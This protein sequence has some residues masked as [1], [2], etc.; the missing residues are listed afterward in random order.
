MAHW[1]AARKNRSKSA[2]R[3]AL[4]VSL[5]ALTVSPALA[6]RVN[7]APVLGGTG[8]L[9][10][11]GRVSHVEVS[12]PTVAQ[13]KPPADAERRS[14]VVRRVEITDGFPEFQNQMSALIAG[15]EGRRLTLAEAY[16][17]TASVQQAYLD[18][19][20]PLVNAVLQ[21]SA[22][23]GGEIRIKIIDGFIESLDLS[24]V[25]TEIRGL[26]RAR[27]SPIVGHG[28]LTKAELQ[29]HIQLLGEL[30]GVTG[31]TKSKL[32]DIPG[33]VVL[34]VSATQ[35]PF[36]ESTSVNN[37]LP[38]E[39][40][41][42]LF[43]QA[44]SLNNA[45]GFGEN[46]HAEF[47]SSDD[48]G[49][50]FD[51]T[52]K[53]EAFSVG[54]FLPIGADG[55]TLGAGYA[56]SRTSPSPTP[57]QLDT[58]DFASESTF[59]EF[60][61]LSLR[62]GYP[63]LLAGGQS[64]HGQIGFDFVDNVS[65][66]GPFPYVNPGGQPD[67]NLFHDQYEDLRAGAEWH[68]AF[69]WAWG[70]NAITGAIYTHG[71]AGL[72]GSVADPLS[73]PGASPDFNKLYGEIRI[74]QPLPESLVFSALGRAQTSFGRSLMESEELQLAGP[75]ALSGFGL[76]TI[77]ADT[78]AVGRA[79]LQ[80]PFA[81]PLKGGAAVATP[82][83]FG[84]A[85][86][87]RFEDV[88]PGEDANV[89]ATSFG[90]GLRAAAKFT[91]WPFYE[92]LDLELARVN[93]NVPFTR[94]GY[95]AT[96]SYQMAYSGDPFG[97]PQLGQEGSA[98]LRT[99]DFTSGFYAGVNSGYAFD[100]SPR[101]ASTGKVVSDALDENFTPSNGAEV[102]AANITGTAP[103]SADTP[104]G[105]G[106][107][108]YNFI[109]DR[110]VLGG[111]ADIQGAGQA[112][113]SQSVR[114]S[115]ATIIGEAQP[116]T[117]VFDDS[118]SLDW[119]GTLRGRAGVLATPGLLAYVT[120]GLAY[121]GVSANTRATQ[122][123]PANVNN[124][125]YSLSSSSVG[126]GGFS[127]TLMGWTAGAGLE[128][129]FAPG[130]SV[131]GEYLYYDLGEGHFP[132]GVLVTAPAGGIAEENVVASNSSARF[133]G[134]IVRIGLNYYFGARDEPPPIV[135]KGP[136]E[137][138]RPV[139]NGYYAG[140]NAGYDFGFGSSASNSAKIGSTD[141]DQNLGV[142][143]APYLAA[144]IAGNSK[145]APNGFIG[146]G[147]VGY[148][149]ALDRGLVGFEA[150][151]QETGAKGHGAY[152][153][154]FSSDPNNLFALT[155]HV[156]NAT[157]VDWLG[158]LRGRLGLFLRSDLLAYTTGGL[159]YGETSSG[160]FIDQKWSGTFFPFQ[161]SG[162]IGLNNRLMAGWTAGAGLEWMFSRDLSL[163]GEYLFY[164]LGVARYGASPSSLAFGLSD[165][166]L[167]STAFRYNGQILRVGLNYHF[168]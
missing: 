85:A 100:A 101:I 152:T 30:P 36:A 151:M 98:D 111:E 25:P 140:L 145:A 9:S 13:Q 154:Y 52:A 74:Q 44:F 88:Y 130:F 84:A 157:A 107:V 64:L 90:G 153:N 8:A 159:A 163:K 5:A 147:Q 143:F 12:I 113:I 138:S 94:E 137:E 121:G 29:R 41:T 51:G 109:D 27:L 11:G 114:T 124:T 54:G 135:V 78:G 76:G 63:L 96:F 68:V 39:D 116:V 87:G 117:T 164:D 2:T 165:T 61:R 24:G 23:A 35:T 77:Y 144:L 126:S 28:H 129:M 142:D 20:Y 46:L 60:Q 160:T 58:G 150:D 70:G 43:S 122:S 134:H 131:K 19:G 120:G 53:S 104:L 105:G 156:D 80:R 161:T 50:V 17:F 166:A 4:I 115:T 99:S 34:E 3:Q 123:W 42:Y 128:W 146:G 139:W 102:S 38:E 10:N 75:D 72:P 81:V 158:T 47:A 118:K 112:S 6:Q 155:T 97:A 167:P 168:N 132:S 65:T 83:I 92:T 57:V 148:N 48:F 31:S 1:V 14:A 56:Q 32:G 127:D 82:Y 55:F 22:F 95:S 7:L 119:L 40:G 21:P 89:S 73:R 18:A 162:S 62:A 45:L 91:G 15:V 49:H 37:Y 66:L 125:P 141:L 103:A 16:Q 69:P 26:V 106:Q 110:W 93:S 133:N 108:G 67:F 149:L 79:E 136:S 59:D 33:G 71:L 86:R